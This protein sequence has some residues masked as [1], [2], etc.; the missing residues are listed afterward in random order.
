[1]GDAPRAAR[2]R[3]GG[4][5]RRVARARG[6]RRREPQ[7]PAPRRAARPAPRAL[8]PARVR[9]REARKPGRRVADDGRAADVQPAL[10]ARRHVPADLQGLGLR[11][12]VARRGPVL[13]RGRFARERRT[14]TDMALRAHEAPRRRGVHAPRRARALRA[15]ALRR[16]NARLRGVPAGPGLRSGRRP[17]EGA[18]ALRL[19]AREARPRDA[20][21]RGL[22]RHRGYVR[23]PHARPRGRRREAHA[24]RPAHHGGVPPPGRLR[25]PERALRR[26]L[27]APRRPL[28]GTMST[29]VHQR[30]FAS[31]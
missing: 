22:A 24:A 25:R 17:V 6:T 12:P 11:E 3:D 27:R 14:E 23:L 29:N 4:V 13:L 9:E 28:L 30:M 15:R 18:R 26:R 1:M 16:A 19:R 8:R 31:G 10:D 7:P 2:P 5:P 20:P 21:G